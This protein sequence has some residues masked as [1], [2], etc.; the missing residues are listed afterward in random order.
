MPRGYC[1][2]PELAT[3]FKQALVSK[4]LDPFKLAKLT[5]D[6]RRLAIEKVIGK[7]NAKE[8]NA[9]F[10]SK[11][12]LRNQKLGFQTW[13][14]KV[15]GIDKRTKKD[16]FERIEKLDKVLSPEE[17]KLFLKD[18]AESKLGIG[19]T[20]N[21]AT[22]IVKLADEVRPFANIKDEFGLPT[23][24]YMVKVNELSNYIESITP[25]LGKVDAI[26]V[27]SEIAGLTRTLMTSADFSASFRQGIFLAARHPIKFTKAFFGQFRPAFSE[28]AFQQ[29]Q[30]A[31]KTD[32]FFD[33]V[34]RSKLAITELG[35]TLTKREEAFTSSFI[36]R[37]PILGAIP[38]GSARAYATFLNKLRFDVFK[39]MVKD[40][41]KVGRNPVDDEK[42]LKDIAS[43]VNA[44][45][46]RGGLGRLEPAANSLAQALFSPRLI[47][48]RLSLMNPVYYAKLD[49]LVRKEALKS[50]FAFT[51]A[52]TAL[53]TIAKLNGA[54]VELDS[55]SSDFGKAKFGRTRVDIWGGF[56]QY[57]RFASQFATGKSKSTTTGVVSDKNRLDASEAFFTSKSSPLTSYIIQWAKGENYQ[58]KPFDPKSEAFKRFIPIITEDLYELYK[59]DDLSN[60]PYQGAAVF[61]FGV[62]TYDKTPD[63]A[64]WSQSTGKELTQFKEKVGEDKFKEAENKFNQEYIKWFEETT[65][66][67]TYQGLSDEDKSSLI[68]TK[69]DKL[70]DAIFKEYRFTYKQEKQTSEQKQQKKNL[71]GLAK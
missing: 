60:V 64:R 28:K 5:S 17:E 36:E 63:T 9:L 59:Q 35:N 2:V 52:G 55:K 62:Q 54:E 58:G 12:L 39:G 68:K 32:P 70:K 31:I 30:N 11:L 38:R 66:T 53:L 65:K 21:E 15:G 3:K 20:V 71:E 61:G 42:L 14:K 51:S 18:L 57:I 1:L 44:G 23:K 43:F 41:Q 47:S 67:P 49:P 10:E 56:Q 16:L 8:V 4:Q 24:D 26:R 27:A 7:A 50:L 25:N 46:G 69:K 13:A 6:E 29:S 40:A 22:Q 37:V 48:S 34:P 33:L 45:T 19:V